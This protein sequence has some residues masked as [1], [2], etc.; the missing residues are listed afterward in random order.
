MVDVCM[1]GDM[2]EIGAPGREGVAAAPLGADHRRPGPDTAP[3]LAVL[4][5]PS[6]YSQKSPQKNTKNLDE[7]TRFPGISS[8]FC[9]IEPF[10]LQTMWLR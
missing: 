1:C 6:A 9:E 3:S 2:W 8:K 7:N 4:K 10:V 5:N